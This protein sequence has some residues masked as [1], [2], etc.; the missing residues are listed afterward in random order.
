[1]G[2]VS[3]TILMSTYSST[4]LQALKDHLFQPSISTSAETRRAQQATNCMYTN[5]GG[6]STCTAAD[7]TA[8]LVG[9]RHVNAVKRIQPLGGVPSLGFSL[10]RSGSE[11]WL[12]PPV[13]QA[14]ERWLGKNAS[15]IADLGS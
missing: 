12:E 2:Q 14:P 1:M 4:K 3:L 10:A 8:A 6:W 7:I 13:Q 5:I 15:S 9:F 11:T